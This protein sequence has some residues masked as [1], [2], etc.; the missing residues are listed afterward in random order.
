MSHAN[1][2]EG[3]FHLLSTLAICVKIN[4]THWTQEQ[5]ETTTMLSGC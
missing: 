3:K 5:M 4:L 1:F 2:A